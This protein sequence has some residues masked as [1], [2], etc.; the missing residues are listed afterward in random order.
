MRTLTLAQVGG[1]PFD[2]IVAD[3]SFIS[4]RSVAPVLLGPV[5]APGGD[6]V[7]LIK[8]QFEAGRQAASVGRGIIRTP[9]CGRRRCF[10]SSPP[11]SPSVPR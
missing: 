6:A 9:R 7:L 2:L 4:L 10:A 1:A 3:L 8:P 11:R 5:A